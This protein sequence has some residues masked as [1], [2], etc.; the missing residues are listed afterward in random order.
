MASA[1]WASTVYRSPVNAAFLARNGF[2]S[3]I[4][5]KKPKSRTMP[6]SIR[7]ANNANSKI[8][9][10][11]EHLFAQQK[12]RMDLFIR[13]IGIALA[14]ITIGMGNFVYI[15]KRLLCLRRIAA[16]R[17]RRLSEAT[18]FRRRP[19]HASRHSVAEA[20]R[21]TSSRGRMWLLGCVLINRDRHARLRLCLLCPRKRRFLGAI[22]MSAKGQHRTHALQHD[23]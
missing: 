18:L 21:K 5:R 23:R 17:R 13:T 14:T 12:D 20:H 22:P 4:H 10:R 1:V 7:R 9:S 11:V 6:N 3:H 15:N 8:R 19:A 2:V 16:V